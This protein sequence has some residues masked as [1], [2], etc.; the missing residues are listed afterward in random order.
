MNHHDYKVFWLLSHLRLFRTNRLRR[1]YLIAYQIFG[2]FFLLAVLHEECQELGQGTPSKNI[3]M[4]IFFMLE[5]GF[6][7]LKR[8]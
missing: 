3:S 5:M 8:I 4:L 2:Q 7:T 6:C 1:F